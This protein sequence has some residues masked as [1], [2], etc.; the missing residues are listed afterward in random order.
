[1]AGAAAGFVASGHPRLYDRE[2]S[3]T[4]SGG[5]CY[6]MQLGYRHA[7]SEWAQRKAWADH[8]HEPTPWQA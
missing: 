7:E 1:V 8:S 2:V 3:A 6:P 5:A 4:R